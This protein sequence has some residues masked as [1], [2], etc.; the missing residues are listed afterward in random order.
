MSFRL[1]SLYKTQLFSFSSKSNQVYSSFKVKTITP[2][3]FSGTNFDINNMSHLQPSKN[4][5]RQKFFDDLYSF[6]RNLPIIKTSNTALK[7]KEL[8]KS[9]NSKYYHDLIEKD[10]ADKKIKYSPKVGDKIEIEYFL[11]ISSNKLNRFKGVIVALHNINTPEFAF[12]FYTKVDGYY[13]T[14]R[15]NFFSDIIKSIK[16][17]SKS[18]FN[19]KSNHLVGYKK[20]GYIGQ[21]GGLVLKGG[22]HMKYT[23]E[24]V[25]NLKETLKDLENESANTKSTLFDI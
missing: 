11:S 10:K 25:L 19:Y 8:L 13:L 24:D 23:K 6:E 15:F 9:I 5:K 18:N 16:L 2:S 20:L 4:E 22:K 3:L 14:L 21:K 7:G 1:C 17:V 12:S